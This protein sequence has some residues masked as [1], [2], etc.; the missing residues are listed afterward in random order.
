MKRWQFWLGLLISLIFLYFAL[1]GLG[2]QDL[3]QALTGANYW[4]LAPGVAAYFLAVWAR[5][6]RW[7]YLIRPIKSVSTR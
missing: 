7:H 5:A 6:W 2:L 1:R 4:W 3:G